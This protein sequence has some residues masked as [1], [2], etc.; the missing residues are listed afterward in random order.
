MLKSGGREAIKPPPTTQK[1]TQTQP[2]MEFQAK[3]HRG[4]DGMQQAVMRFTAV[5]M[6]GAATKADGVRAVDAFLRFLYDVLLLLHVVI[7]SD[8]RF[9][10]GLDPC[11]MSLF[12][13]RMSTFLGDGT[14]EASVE[15]S[16]E[17]SGKA[18]DRLVLTLL[19][20]LETVPDRSAAAQWMFNVYQSTFVCFFYA[21]STL[22]CIETYAT[23]QGLLL[24]NIVR[25]QAMLVQDICF[26]E[27]HLTPA[28]LGQISEYADAI[29]VARKKDD[30][31]RLL[32]FLMGT[33]ARLGA[34]S[35]LRAFFPLLSD[36]LGEMYP[37]PAE[38]VLALWLRS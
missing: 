28:V 18:F 38:H 33:H 10:F 35:V 29:V 34:A 6:T 23:P 30:D 4:M 25:T 17:A 13:D 3:L 19:S 2:R 12:M 26:L 31:E 37:A 24:G 32:A 1:A 15:A 36:V 7:A 9:E 8:A 5:G 14:A 22:G 20:Q 21:M 16:A 27:R 11:T